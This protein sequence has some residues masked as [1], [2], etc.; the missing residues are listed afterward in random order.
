[1]FDKN[2]YCVSSRIENSGQL[3]GCFK[4]GPFSRHQSLTFAN[5][6]RRT[7]LA[8]RSRCTLSA[9]QINDVEHEFSSLIGVRE[10]VVDILLN[11]EKLIFKI[12]KPITKPQV[13]FIN[14][15][16][17]GILRAQH[18]YLPS[19]FQCVRPSQ[20]I[21]TLEV[22]GKLTLKLFFSPDWNKFQFF[23]QNIIF[24]TK[25]DPKNHYFK[26]S[27]KKKKT[28]LGP[29][30]Q[31]LTSPQRVEAK[32][33]AEG[34]A[35]DRQKNI[36]KLLKY[37]NKNLFKEIYRH[38][39]ILHRKIHQSSKA[40][41]SANRVRLPSSGRSNSAFPFLGRANGR[42]A[43]SAPSQKT[44]AS[45]F[46]ITQIFKNRLKIV[47]YLTNSLFK[48]GH[49]NYFQ[50]LN[51]QFQFLNLKTMTIQKLPWS[52][53][54]SPLAKQSDPPIFS[55]AKPSDN[56]KKLVP[57]G[58][59]QYSKQHT[60]TNSKK[61]GLGASTLFLKNQKTISLRTGLVDLP[62]DVS[63]V[64]AQKIQEN[65]LFLNGSQCAIEKVNYT[66]QSILGASASEE[67]PHQVLPFDQRLTHLS[68]NPKESSE[69]T[70][71]KDDS[72][73]LCVAPLGRSKALKASQEAASA[74][75]PRPLQE[76]TTGNSPRRASNKPSGP[77]ESSLQ[78][79]V[80]PRS[81]LGE[82]PK[83]PTEAAN[84]SNNFKKSQKI[85][86]F[87]EKKSF[88]LKCHLKLN[89]PSHI[90][91][92]LRGNIQ[93][94]ANRISP[95][96][97]GFR[98]IQPVFEDKSKASR[99]LISKNEE[100]ILFEIWTDGSIL[101]QTAFLRAL[102]E[103]LLEIFPYS[104]QISKYEKV[105][106]ILNNPPHYGR[107]T[108]RFALIDRPIGASKYVDRGNAKPSG[109]VWQAFSSSPKAKAETSLRDVNFHDLNRKNSL[110]FIQNSLKR[111]NT[112]LSK[113]SFREKF[114]NLEIGNFYFDLETYLF[115][116]K[117][118]IH[119]II[120]FFK[121]LN[122]KETTKFIGSQQSFKNH[123]KT[124]EIKMTLDQFQIFLNS[125]IG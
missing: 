116:K 83:L 44:L 12:K 49:N 66:L 106:S 32:D 2:F 33:I 93:G 61:T 102:N 73:L 88:H 36:Q 60:K 26:H 7:L 124:K 82:V 62:Q 55:S 35:S 23:L 27:N 115:L 16:G 40:K 75:F 110:K 11:L 14:F 31:R 109:R 4:I 37:T 72:P 71:A 104:L 39:S 19:N 92:K 76:E 91:R 101:P 59:V 125:L 34:E 108:G 86:N 123:Q 6:L 114:L 68:F 87:A 57:Y 24:A 9:V 47:H 105:N 113:K 43:R 81:P 48:S 21:A 70:L 38:R 69:Q 51:V 77:S 89:S 103:L 29:R 107:N 90:Q 98:A 28:G 42:K 64:F 78:R 58:N 15:C 53:R 20:Y 10:S 1:M 112:D 79:F 41:R 17:P 45:A 96:T 97:Q 50:R 95:S 85:H 118:K 52:N 63:P 111:R 120:D 94:L 56:P 65:F 117:R 46:S 121:F 100:F 99:R 119:R 30:A 25:E 22:D 84:P 18:I 67:N 54:T 74:Y 8:D 80:P 3:Y 13:A 122:Q 5:A